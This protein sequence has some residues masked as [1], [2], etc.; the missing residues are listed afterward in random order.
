MFLAGQITVELVN[1][2]SFWLRMHFQP[3][4]DFTIYIDSKFSLFR[5]VP[6]MVIGLVVGIVFAALDL[7]LNRRSD[8]RGEETLKSLLKHLFRSL[9]VAILFI[10]VSTGIKGFILI[11]YS[12]HRRYHA[13]PPDIELSNAFRF[14]PFLI[15]A[16]AFLWAM[17]KSLRHP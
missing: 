12:M 1:R 13:Y 9:V 2:I 4:T 16:G 11:R 7:A 17:N 5:F 3:P 14:V 8:R 15:L 6:G 10:I